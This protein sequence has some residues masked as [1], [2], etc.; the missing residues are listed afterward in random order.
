[1]PDTIIGLSTP[2][3][4][5]IGDSE[6][7]VDNIRES[8]GGEWDELTDGDGDIITA[9]SHGKKG[10]VSMDFVLKDGSA[11]SYLLQPAAVLTLPTGETDIASSQTLYLVNW[12]KTKSKG[13]WLSGTL[14]ANYY[15][16][17]S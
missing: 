4:G 11:A 6:I 2:V 13:G 3:W 5:T 9:V 1:M 17:M 15:P 10:E 14:T 12:E 7:I 16:S 8:Y